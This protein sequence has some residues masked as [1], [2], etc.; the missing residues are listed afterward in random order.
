M[1]YANFRYG[2]RPPSP[3]EGRGRKMKRALW[4]AIIRTAKSNMSEIEKIDDG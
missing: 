1:I 4:M 2:Y 3:E